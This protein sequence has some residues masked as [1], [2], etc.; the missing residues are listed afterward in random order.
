MV[1]ALW[2]VVHRGFGVRRA[3]RGAGPG[4]G[5]AAAAAELPGD[6]GDLRDRESRAWRPRWPGRPVL[7]VL[8]NLEHLLPEA[9]PV[10]GRAGRPPARSW[11]GPAGTSRAALRVRA[12]REVVLSPAGRPHDA[13][14]PARRARRQLGLFLRP[15]LPRRAR[16]WSSTSRTSLR[17]R[18]SADGWTISAPRC[19]A[20]QRP[21]AAPAD[22]P[23]HLL[24]R[25]D[26]AAIV[27]DAARPGGP[28][29]F[30]VGDHRL[31]PGSARL[32][33]GARPVPAPR[34]VHGWFHPERR[35]GG[36]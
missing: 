14:R 29:A 6:P 2:P 17:W 23:E 27:R 34:R 1:A 24:E 32:R 11:P 7:V 21:G 20:R 12:E 26:C 31:E 30:D 10:G 35:G 15:E 13:S 4:V 16:S 8:D 25:L 5:A 19:R 3:G 9:A 18:R 22:A 33:G 28:S 36:R